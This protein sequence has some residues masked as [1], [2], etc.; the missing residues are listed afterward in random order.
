MKTVQIESSTLICADN[1]EALPGFVNGERCTAVVSDPPYGIFF[2]GRDWDHG[3]PGPHFWEVI[4]AACLPGAPLLAFGGTRTFHRLV[5]AIEDA[6]WE[7]RDTL[8]WLHGQGFPKSLDISKAIDKLGGNGTQWFIDYVLQVCAERGIPRKELTALF[9]S[10]NGKTTG[11]LYNKSSHNQSLTPEQFN[12]IRRFLNLPFADIAEAEREIVGSKSA[13]LGSGKTYAF[14]EANGEA[15]RTVAITAPATDA[16][17]LWHGY[18]TA[19]KPAFEPICLAMNPLDGTFAENALKHGVAGLAIDRCRVGTEV[20]TWPASRRQYPVSGIQPGGNANGQTVQTGGAPSGRWPANFIHDG[21]DE[22]LAGFPVTTS[23]AARSGERGKR[24]GGFGNVGAEK[25][26]PLPCGEMYGDTG[27]AA[28][29]FYCAKASRSEREAG[30]GTNAHPTVKPIALM[31]YLVRLV[32]MPA[33]NRILDPFMGSGTTGVACAMAGVPFVGI[34]MNPDYFEIACR[35]IEHAH[36]SRT[37][38]TPELLPA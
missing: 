23:G 17:K 35:R 2:M 10:K 27:S 6:G 22:V 29:F 37:L 25:G 3:I 16:A 7:V 5:C 14:Q 13:G 38:K 33:H 12:T 32:T 4:A 18:G 34:E 36:R 9:P 19:L 8:M 21:S 1:R 26:D 24:P 20:E 31:Q 15:P 30:T 11:W 28:R